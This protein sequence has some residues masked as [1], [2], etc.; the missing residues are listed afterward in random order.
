[1]EENFEAAKGEVGL[2]HYEVRHWQGWY[3]HIT[4]SMVAHA[5]L[6]VTQRSAQLPPEVEAEQEQNMKDPV[7]KTQFEAFLRWVTSFPIVTFK[8]PKSLTFLTD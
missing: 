4:L 1:M 5:Y 6:T 2:D 8:V 7:V 3:R